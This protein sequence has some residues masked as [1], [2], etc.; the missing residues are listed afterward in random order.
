[1]RGIPWTDQETE[2]L[3]DVLFDVPWFLACDRYNQWAAANGFPARTASAMQ[4]RR[5]RIGADTRSHGEWLNCQTIGNILDCP[6]QRPLRWVKRWPDILQPKQ[7]FGPGGPIFIRRA[8]IR[9]LARLHPDQFAGCKR[10]NL[11]ILFEVESLA[12]HIAEHYA[13]PM[14]RA[15]RR[16]RPVINITTGETFESISDAARSVGRD[17]APLW[18]GIRRRW[19]VAGFRWAYAD[20][21][22]EAAA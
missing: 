22:Q 11:V 14:P 16:R 17:K 4:S 1:M 8:N 5:N 15:L 19:A 9:R 20:H 13:A 6:R 18:R 21:Q 12:D 10:P 2:A 7:P 3:L